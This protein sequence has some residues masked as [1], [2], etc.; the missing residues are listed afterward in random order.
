MDTKT[1]SKKIVILGAGFGGLRAAQVLSKNLRALTL[2]DTYEIVLVDRNDHHTYTPLLYEVATTPQETVALRDLHAVA[3][4]DIRSII[5]GTNIQFIHK[6]IECIEPMEGRVY[7]MDGET[8]V[9]QFIVLALGSET[10]YFGIPGLEKYSLPFKTF[11]DAIRIRDAVSDC[12]SQKTAEVNPPTFSHGNHSLEKIGLLSRSPFGQNHKVFREGGRVKIVIGGAGPTGVELA[13]EFKNW[14][15]EI[16]KEFKGCRIDVTLI[17]GAKTILP[18]LDERVIALATR[19]LNYLNVRVV[20]EK[21]IA[22]AKKKAVVF[23]TGDTMPFDVLVWAGGVKAPEL[24]LNASV[25]TEERNRAIVGDGMKCL[26]QTPNLNFAMHVYGLGD[27]ICF[28][29]PVTKRPIPGVARAAI[30]QGNVVAWNII[31][32]IKKLEISTYNLKPKTYV[33]KKYAYVV[34]VGGKYAVA[35]VG[36][37]IISGIFGWILKGLVELNYLLS[38]MSPVKAAR[39]WFK[40]LA[41]FMRTKK[42]G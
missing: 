35:K 40:G 39:I 32:E 29:D 42:L 20:T 26:P 3:A 10:N 12:A 36:P 13:S 25:K 30:S 21:K 6:K 38:I 34:P 15:E 18:G 7:F 14:C 1:L 8:I 31:E 37:I 19:R 17:E 16:E 9:C 41:I 33:P 5:D 2:S 28:Y 27:S 24:L 11:A 4:Y 23:D 22:C